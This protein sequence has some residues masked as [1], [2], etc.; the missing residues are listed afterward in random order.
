MAASVS[1]RAGNTGSDTDNAL[2]VN[3]NQIA[4]TVSF[5]N[6]VEQRLRGHS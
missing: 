3:K 6:L 4:A 1:D 2:V 5:G